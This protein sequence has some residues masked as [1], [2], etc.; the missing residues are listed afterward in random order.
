M[1]EGARIERLQVVADGT[2]RV[3][4]TK[5]SPAPQFHERLQLERFTMFANVNVTFAPGINALVGEN[6]TGKTQLMKALYAYQLA[7][8]RGTKP[9]KQ[10]EGVYQTENLAELV[11]D[12]DKNVLSAVAAG[13]YGGQEW[14]VGVQRSDSGYTLTAEGLQAGVSRPVFIPATDMLARA[15]AFIAT[16]DEY[17]IDFDQTYRDTVSPLLAPEKRAPTQHEEALELL[18]RSI[19][20]RVAEDNERFYLQR[21]GSRQPMPLAGE[22]LRKLATL[23]LL[24][25]NGWLEPGSVLFWDEPES[26]VNP[27]GGGGEYG[28]GEWNR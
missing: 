24:I 11:S 19:G 1:P 6:G 22:G 12:W 26:N 16:Y 20:G 4:A 10:L 27:A 5:K 15:K 18:A 23:L 2:N 7:C 3:D 25:Q 28:G 9:D 13:S 21:N 17:R 8:F 14:R